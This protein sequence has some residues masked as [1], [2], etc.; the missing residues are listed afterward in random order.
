[1]SLTRSYSNTTIKRLYG[2]SGRKCGNPDCNNLIIDGNQQNIG[3]IAHIKA[4]EAGGPR[5]DSSLPDE[6]L[7]GYNNLIVLCPTCHSKVDQEP[8]FYTV[9]KLHEWK[10]IQEEN[11]QV[12]YIRNFEKIITERENKKEKCISENEFYNKELIQ[13]VIKNNN[14]Q[15]QVKIGYGKHLLSDYIINQLKCNKWEQFNDIFIKGLAGSGKTSEMK[16]AF[17]SLLDEFMDVKKLKKYKACVVPLF[18]ELKDFQV[19]FI[20]NIDVNYNYLIFLDGLDELSEEN[21]PVFFKS[22]NN[23]RKQY[24]LLKFIISGRDASFSSQLFNFNILRLDFSDE[25]ND[26]ELQFLRNKFSNTPLES[27]VKIPAYREFALSDKSNNLKTY[28]DFMDKLIDETLLKDKERYDNANEITP[29]TSKLS[30][31]LDNIKNE[32]SIFVYKLYKTGRRT[33]SE[34][35][36]KFYFENEDFQFIIKSAILDY[37]NETNIFFIS[38]IY[39]EYFLALYL[40][41]ETFSKVRKIFFINRTN[42]IIVSQI[43]TLAILLNIISKD[44]LLFKKLTNVL[45]KNSSVYILLTDY[46]TLSN[47]IRFDYYNKIIDEFNSKK[48]LVYYTRFSSSNDILANIPD[49][50]DRLHELLPLSFQQQAINK[51]IS[52]VQKFLNNPAEDNLR[53]FSNAVILLGFGEEKYWDYA[54]QQQLQKV[55]I[56]LL[57]FFLNNDLAKKVKGLLSYLVVFLWYKTYCWTDDWQKNDWIKFIKEIGC[58]TTNSLYD[59]ADDSDY[60]IKLMIFVHFYKNPAV[61]KLFAPLAVKIINQKDKDDDGS[62]IPGELDDNFVIK[63]SVL[64]SEVFYFNSIIKEEASKITLEELL[65]IWKALV[66]SQTSFGFDAFESQEIA[67]EIEAQFKQQA[68][69]LTEKNVPAL[70]DILTEYITNQKGL[71]LNNFE[72]Y[73]NI[74]PESIKISLLES[75]F[76]DFRNGKYQDDFY[77]S[78]LVYKLLNITDKEKAQNLIESLNTKTSIKI[79]NNIIVAGHVFKDEHPCNDFCNKKYPSVCPNQYQKELKDNKDKEQYESERNEML[80]HEAEIITSFDKIS[81]EIDKI[82]NYLDSSVNTIGKD[83]E[84]MNLI[85]LE[86]EEKLYRFQIRQAEG[87]PKLPVFS[88]CV[89]KMLED[90]SFN[91]DKKVHRKDFKENLKD[92]ENSKNSFWRFFFWWYIR[93]HNEG[94]LNFINDNSS[95]LTNIKDSM[96]AEIPE[97]L[98]QHDITFYDGGRNRNWVAPFIYYLNSLY[99]NELPDWVD[100]DFLLNM[101]AFP[102]WSLSVNYSVHMGGEYKWENWESVFEWL[103]D[104]TGISEDEITEKALEIYP[105]LQ[106]DISKTQILTLFERKIT[107]SPEPHPQILNII[108][109]ESLKEYQTPYSENDNTTSIN[110]NLASFWNNYKENEVQ[111]LLPHLQFKEYLFNDKNGCRKALFEYVSRLASFEQKTQIIKSIKNK[112]SDLSEDQKYILCLLGDEKTNQALIDEFI[113]GKNLNSNLYYRGFL[114]G[115]TKASKKL[116]NA[117]IKLFV[118]SLE[119]PSERRNE[120]HQISVNMINSSVNRHNFKYLK[121]ALSRL[122]KTRKEKNEYFEYVQGYLNEVEQK[123]YT[124]EGR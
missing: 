97:L 85:Y 47:E 58:N 86:P 40:S 98:R 50:A 3:E 45:N 84:R 16:F 30:I 37:R 57:Q 123:V 59:F 108:V 24:P 55:A 52:D 11:T 99:N 35:D 79:Y 110:F 19:N 118:Y 102:S 112:N 105:L 121:K 44:D 43:N 119:G 113:K 96:A 72:Q 66:V 100:K 114:F 20:Q 33:F 73:I 65:S 80:S 91:D 77:I 4:F 116:F 26:S 53:E 67:K 74:L 89:V 21:T 62:F 5:Y 76:V 75:L 13:I 82:F 51:H 64:D 9:E 14:I 36:L 8:L 69:L 54:C 46:Q 87:L 6:E 101:I 12:N 10:E 17:N 115:T 18:F 63:T 25:K 92:W 1:M 71:Y 2:V 94:V 104:V 22:I 15:D 83:T 88:E 93:L 78:Y 124:N 81:A 70:Y 31:Y 56:P 109:S 107:N 122:I 41:N 29:R 34:N 7:N 27:L 48:E 103:H 28:K 111:K 42:S 61:W 49:L 95:I 39:Y 68:H 117:Y 120:L 32:F 23:L 90:A 106:T 60:R 38:N